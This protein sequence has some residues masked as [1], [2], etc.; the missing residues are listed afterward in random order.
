MIHLLIL[1]ITSIAFILCLI[2]SYL[3]GR[4]RGHMQGWRE[5]AEWQRI[6]AEHGLGPEETV[7]MSRMEFP[8][9][10]DA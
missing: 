2:L 10:K 4:A 8:S 9:R 6:I 3:A 5:N 7:P 1:T